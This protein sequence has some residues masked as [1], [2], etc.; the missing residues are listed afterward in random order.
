[1]AT[2]RYILNLINNEILNQAV[3]AS[4]EKIFTLSSHTTD[5]LMEALRQNNCILAYLNAPI[6]TPAKEI[7]MRIFEDAEVAELENGDIVLDKTNGNLTVN[8]VK[9]K[10]NRVVVQVELDEGL[11]VMQ[12]KALEDIIVARIT[13]AFANAINK[14]F[15]ND[16][17]AQGVAQKANNANGIT[18][19][20]LASL[21][22]NNG[23]V[24]VSRA[25]L[26]NAL[27]IDK[28]DKEILNNPRVHLFENNNEAVIIAIED[29]NAIEV[30]KGADEIQAGVIDTVGFLTNTKVFGARAS[31]GFLVRDPKKVQAIIVEPQ[32]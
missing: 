12:G 29:K 8:T 18:G 7:A 23:V 17:V 2:E 19:T 13:D 20:I 31:F 24:L 9:I 22:S 16:L 15:I 4:G 5:K 26:N 25:F 6:P 1:M 14:K 32:E 10:V 27:G 21:K 28:F 30:Y 3:D 11:F